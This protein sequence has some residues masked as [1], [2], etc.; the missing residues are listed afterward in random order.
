VAAVTK[1]TVEIALETRTKFEFYFLALTFTVLALSIHTANFGGNVTADAFELTGWGVLLSAGIT[2][3]LRAEWIPA[4]YEMLGK[5]DWAEQSLARLRAA[6]AKREELAMTFIE[7]GRPIEFGTAASIDRLENTA[8]EL[9]RQAS[10]AHERIRS[11]YIWM[12]SLFLVGI[13]CVVL[14]RGIPPAASLWARSVQ[15]A[16]QA[17]Q[18]GTAGCEPLRLRIAD[19][20]SAR[21]MRTP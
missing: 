14:A 18:C 2:G 16:Q 19:A 6:Q 20:L 11:R 15:G 3:L 10:L 7:Q 17:A 9:E 5:I 13:A 21:P 12:R 8:N 4:A 1:S